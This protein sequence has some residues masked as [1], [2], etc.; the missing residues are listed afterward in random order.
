MRNRSKALATV[1]VLIV[2]TVAGPGLGTASAATP[3]HPAIAA[4]VWITTPDGTDKMADLGTVA[5]SD[6][7]TTAPT[8]IGASSIHGPP[9]PSK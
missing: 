7:P 3:N 5:F 6:A 4:H 9:R 2:A 8:G 1:G